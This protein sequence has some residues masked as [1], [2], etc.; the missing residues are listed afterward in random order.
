MKIPQGLNFESSIPAPPL[1][2]ELK[3]GENQIGFKIY[4]SGSTESEESALGLE[5]NCCNH[6]NLPSSSP[7]PL[8]PI[9]S[10]TQHSESNAAYFSWPTSS[11]LIDAAEDRANYF[12]NLQ[13]GVLP[14]TL[15]QLPSGQQATTLLELMTIRAFHSKKLRRFSLGTAIGFRIRQGVL[16]D[17]PAIIVFVSR[18]VHR[19]WLSQFQCL[20]AALEGPGGVW[21]DVDVVEFSYYG[22]P[23]ATPKEQLYTE[24]VDGLRG[25]D[26]IIG[27]G[28]QVAS[29]ETYGTLG[30][31]VKSRT[32]NRQVGFLTNRHVAVDLDYP[33][34]KMFHPLPPS[35]GPGVYL[36]AV[37]RA[38]SFITD[39]LWYGI[40]AG[41]NPET[42]VR[43]DGAFIPFA[44]DFNMN[45]VTTTVK[46]VGQIG[47]VHIIDLQSPISCLIG[48]QVVKVGRS[49]GLTTGTIMAYALEYNDE[50][51]ICFFTDFLVVGENQQTFDLEGDSG[52]LILLTGQTVEKPQPVGIIWGGTANRGRLK[53][54]VGQPPE[55]WTSGV[56]LGRL[57][58]LLELDLI[59]TNEGLQAAMQDQRNASAAGIGSM[60]GESSSLVQ[61]PSKDEIEEN[62]EPINL[63][64]L[65]VLA[66]DEPRQGLILPILRSEYGAEDRVE[67][68]PNMEHQFIPSF[69]GRSHAHDNNQRENQES[70]NLSALRNG[71]D[72]EIYVSLRLGEPGPLTKDKKIFGFLV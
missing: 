22:A 30:A 71:S 44:E 26:P 67:A 35:L 6:L 64:I 70:R 16:T 39:V 47:D 57:L 48:R 46:G 9:A 53:L 50:K 55:N 18:K 38:T 33:N 51:G 8:Q 12:G 65:Q 56:D 52:S 20:P 10:A 24:F 14:E 42:F 34:Q 31:I 69:N 25:S 49:S 2:I 62:F 41:I 37:E 5:R 59:T 54:K 63:N 58:D 40:F 23:A 4:H 21:C 45:N 28:S 11:R 66:E 32:G 27:S 29:Q 1:F 61:V 3:D 17:I 7:S 19:Q 43:A 36:G 68:A 72:E 13:K 15:E 60:V